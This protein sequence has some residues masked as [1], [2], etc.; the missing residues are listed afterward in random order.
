M[1][2]G[3]ETLEA[4]GAD[5]KSP[6]LGTIQ[7]EN[8]NFMLSNCAFCLPVIHLDGWQAVMLSY[9]GNDLLSLC[10]VP[11]IVPSKGCRFVVSAPLACVNWPRCFGS[12][13]LA[14]LPFPFSFPH[15]IGLLSWMFLAEP[16]LLG[17]GS[18]QGHPVVCICVRPTTEDRATTWRPTGGLTRQPTVS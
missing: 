18:P 14:S 8:V 16:F 4:V 1:E 10:N 12:H 15:I 2:T 3:S 13:A 11:S 7:F 17:N 5:G 6:I 9:V